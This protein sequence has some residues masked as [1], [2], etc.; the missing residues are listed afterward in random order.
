MVRFDNR[1]SGLSSHMRGR[2]SPGLLL[3]LAAAR[4]GLPDPPA[5]HARRHGADTVALMDGS[6][7]DRAHVV[8]TQPWPYRPLLRWHDPSPPTPGRPER[9]SNQSH[10]RW[11]ARIGIF[12]DQESC[13]ERRATSTRILVGPE[14]DDKR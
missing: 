9:C 7:I 12:A 2:R 11:D 5:V 6:G 14:R 1:D 8:G 13:M 3:T 10:Y 4:L